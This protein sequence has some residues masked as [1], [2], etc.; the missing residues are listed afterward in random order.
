MNGRCLKLSAN[1]AALA[2]F[3]FAVWRVGSMITPEKIVASCNSP[4]RVADELNDAVRLVRENVGPAESLVFHVDDLSRL[5]GLDRQFVSAIAF[6]RMPAKLPV[7]DCRA[8]MLDSD[9]VI[10]G[11]YS[12]M[13]QRLKRGDTPYGLAAEDRYLSLFTRLGKATRSPVVS[14][15]QSTLSWLRMAFSALTVFVCVGLVSCM[16]S[17][18]KTRLT[19]TSL[20]AVISF[21]IVLAALCVLTHTLRSPN[22][23]AVYAGK[24]KLW[25]TCGVPSGYL[26]DS[27][28]LVFLPAYPPLL[29]VLSYLYYALAGAC[30]NWLVQFVP[31]AGVFWCMFVLFTRAGNALMKSA[32]VLFFSLSY[33][34]YVIAGYYAE[35]YV[36]LALVL[37]LSRI[38]RGDSGFMT[39]LVAGSAALFKN[40]GL[41]FY[42]VLAFSHAVV[43]GC[44]RR[45]LLCMMAGALPSAAWHLAVRA[46]GGGVDGYDTNTLSIFLSH[47][48]EALRELMT[49]FAT[50]WKS[51]IHSLPLLMIAIAFSLK[52][53]GYARCR[54]SVMTGAFCVGSVLA[55]VLVYGFC[56]DW[57]IDW[58]IHSSL[59]RLV[60]VSAA[61]SLWGMATLT[62]LPLAGNEGGDVVRA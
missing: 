54:P 14:S 7:V 1:I 56:S 30:D 18:T 13:A 3:T 21:G 53:K 36:A 61:V 59:F 2:I 20:T 19:L 33:S 8:N 42:I 11:R 48:W 34:I 32:V 29:S 4:S 52:R 58:R 24:A 12:I 25:L 50:E 35:G 37:A 31:F 10:A 51:G 41:L 15:S 46:L 27:A 43:M 39:W 28:W 16:L 62:S 49:L 23:T 55:S 40:E 9:W 26:T 6:D 45:H 47:V 22:G 57:N 17:G 5:D 38:E 44:G 60:W